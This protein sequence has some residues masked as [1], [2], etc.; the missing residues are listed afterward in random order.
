MKLISWN[1]N[2]F[3]AVLKKGFEDAFKTLDADIFCLQET[4]MQPGQAEVDLPGYKQYWN[5]AVKKGYS[6]TAAFCRREPN[7]VK[8]N[9]GSELHNDEGRVLSLFY[10]DFTLVNVY[11]PNAQPELARIAYREEWEDA[12]R[13][14]VT[15][16][17]KQN[18]VI[19]C[20]DMNVARSE[21]D[22]K[23]P[24]A[25]EG[26]AGYSKQ[27]RAKMETLLAA[28]FTDT[29]RYLYPDKTG[30]YTWWTYRAPNARANNAGW[31]IDYF[32]VSNDLDGKIGD[33][34]IYPQ[35][36]GS[37]HCPVGLDLK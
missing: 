26:K 28:G 27:E 5:S 8:F 30:A 21:I 16:L 4:K 12:F 17:K 11:S 33:S 36:M 22:L 10:D 2:G 18:P 20:G 9:F 24:K 14:Y 25:N 3:R 32:L 34:L 1:V 31:R 13:E 6:G 35:V 15:G 7:D 37:D 19:I 29:F 23:N